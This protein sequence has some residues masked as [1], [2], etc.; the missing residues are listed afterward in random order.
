MY[1]SE[2]LALRKGKQHL[3]RKNRDGNVEMDDM[4]KEDYEKIRTEE[5]RE[6]ADMWQT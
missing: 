5:I 3:L 6:R 2:T 1:G 4:N